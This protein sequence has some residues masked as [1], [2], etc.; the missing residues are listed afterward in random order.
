[1]YKKNLKEIIEIFF[2]N[3]V[4]V[5]LTNVTDNGRDTYSKKESEYLNTFS[6]AMRK[7][8]IEVSKQFNSNDVI[9]FDIDEILSPK[10]DVNPTK[11]DNGKSIYDESNHLSDF[12]C[13]YIAESIIK[14]IRN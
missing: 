10:S 6:T 8:I 12:V 13:D 11:T 4:R 14:K 9:Y 5:I 7:I 1:M 2:K 3:N